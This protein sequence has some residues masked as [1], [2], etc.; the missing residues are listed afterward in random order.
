MS[1]RAVVPVLMGS[2]VPATLSPNA[3]SYFALFTAVIIARL[4]TPS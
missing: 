2:R 3:S 4:G 1:W